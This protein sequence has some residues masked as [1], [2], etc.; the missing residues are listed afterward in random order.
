MR[1][2]SALAGICGTL[3]GLAGCL[4]PPSTQ[5][6]GAN[7][8]PELVEYDLVQY[9]QGYPMVEEEPGTVRLFASDRRAREAIDPAAGTDPDAVAS[10]LDAIEFDRDRLLYVAAEGPD[11]NHREIR[12]GN[13]GVRTGASTRSDDGLDRDAPALVGGAALRRSGEADG[14][15]PTGA[16]ALLRAQFEGEPPDQA[17][18]TLEDG[19]QFQSEVGALAED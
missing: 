9:E 18:I 19:W 2:R 5:A 4:N 8:G 7:R 16:S 12:V 11:P 10:V 6:P 13:L 14:D 3:T 1:R 17:L 15:G